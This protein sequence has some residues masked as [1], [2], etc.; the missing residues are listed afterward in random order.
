MAGKKKTKK[1]KIGGS[2][3]RCD[4]PGKNVHENQISDHLKSYFQ[5]AAKH[6]INS[7]KNK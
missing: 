3:T 4:A 1:Q 6:L 5:K 2:K 7:M